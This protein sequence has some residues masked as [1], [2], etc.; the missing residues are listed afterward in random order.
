MEIDFMNLS[1]LPNGAHYEYIMN[2]LERAK[3]HEVVSVKASIEIANLEAAFNIE[4]ANLKVSRASLLTA[5]ITA[6]QKS[7]ADCYNGYKKAV[8]C[9]LNLPDGELVNAAEKLMGHIRSYRINPYSQLDKVTG[10]LTNFVEDLNI[11]LQPEVT[12]LT[13]TPFV[14][15]LGTT[16]EQVRTLLIRRDNERS[17]KVIGAMKSSRELT[18]KMYNILIK[19][20]NALAIIEGE[21]EYATF[22]AETNQQ[23]VRFKQEVLKQ[24][25][26]KPKGDDVSTTEPDQ[27]TEP[28]IPTEPEE[29]EPVVQ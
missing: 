3:N 12:L 16:N 14:T 22:I 10:M 28:D 27:S 19:K 21:A 23:I 29:G 7:R 20:V 24:K 17:T 18:D 5:E 8:K 26:T 11:E 2:V 6:A 1:A 4:N 13:L 9:Y 15:N 25:A